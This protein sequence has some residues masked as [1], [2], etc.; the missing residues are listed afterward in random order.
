M[1]QTG[2]LKLPALTGPYALEYL[3]RLPLP[4]ESEVV[5][6]VVRI[7]NGTRSPPEGM[8]RSA[9]HELALVVKGRVR[10]ETETLAFEAGV[11]ELIYTSPAENHSTTALED[12]ELF[13]VLADEANPTGR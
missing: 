2:V 9:R 1:N 3:H 13:F 7:A 10:V 5:C 8:R 11:G 4:A 12:A 6:G